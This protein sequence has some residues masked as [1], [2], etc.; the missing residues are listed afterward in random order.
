MP[1]LA[2]QDEVSLSLSLHVS[3]Q[4][5]RATWR[6]RGKATPRT[7]ARVLRKLVRRDG[8]RRQEGRQGLYDY[9]GKERPCG[10]S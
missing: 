5:R 3:D 6:P 8:P 2:L 9:N 7:P 1:P 4:T 10:R